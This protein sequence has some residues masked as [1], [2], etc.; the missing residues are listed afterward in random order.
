MTI[1]SLLMIGLNRRALHVDGARDV[2]LRAIVRDVRGLNG[3][4]VLRTCERFEVYA[5]AADAKPCDL[6]QALGIDDHSLMM[7]VR[8]DV[9]VVRHLFRVAS[10]LESRLIGEPHVLGQVRRAAADAQAS[11]VIGAPLHILFAAAIRCGRSVRRHTALG[12]AAATYATLAVQ[13]VATHLRNVDDPQIVILGTGSVAGEIARGLR[14][15]GCAHLTIAGRHDERT[16]A[17]ARSLDARWTRLSELHRVLNDADAIIA[18]TS[19][20][21]PLLRVDHLAHLRRSSCIIDLGMPANVDDAVRAADRITYVGLDDLAPATQPVA[22]ILDAAQKIA[23]DH[24]A[25]FVLQH[26]DRAIFRR[27][28]PRSLAPSRRIDATSPATLIQTAE[29]AA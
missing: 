4:V 16:S 27:P 3:L 1:A 25:R 20:P 14:H 21:T 18:A 9:D 22:A 13:R 6:L 19:A 23:E 24:A 26:S 11:G 2:D 10:G 12:R 15:R 5:S 7:H 8:R 17:L 29:K 28:V